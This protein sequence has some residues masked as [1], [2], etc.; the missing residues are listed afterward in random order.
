MYKDK[1]IFYSLGDFVF[2]PLGDSNSDYAYFVKFDLSGGNCTVTLYPVTISNFP[3]HMDKEA[4]ANYL[5]S[6]SPS[7]SALKINND[8][9]GTIK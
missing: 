1:P 7:C 5:R 6:L 4:G 9:T 8:G 3:S 2:Y